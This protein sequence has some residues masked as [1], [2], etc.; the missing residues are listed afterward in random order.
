MP[1]LHEIHYCPFSTASLTPARRDSCVPGSAST[2]RWLRKLPYLSVHRTP[3]FETRALLGVHPA[4]CKLARLRT[5]PNAQE[6][7]CAT[8]L[9][10]LSLPPSTS[11]FTTLSLPLYPYS[12]LTS[13]FLLSFL[14][15]ILCGS[16]LLLL[17]FFFFLLSLLLL[18]SSLLTRLSFSLSLNLTRF[19][20]SFHPSSL[21]GT[22][23]VRLRRNCL[24]Q[25][26][27]PYEL[28]WSSSSRPNKSTLSPSSLFFVFRCYLAIVSF[29]LPP[30]LGTL[31]L[32][33]L[34]GGGPSSVLPRESSSPF[35]RYKPRVILSF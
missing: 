22:S 9:Y 16:S 15:P 18:L 21:R 23:I 19:S 35:E 12:T 3:L 33:R 28:L 24:L 25:L 5:K 31:K 30:S 17:L 29:S 13:H 8:S 6:R 20:A 27:L 11:F 32:V 1:L 4:G 7:T 14:L 26:L 34:R 2:S 10:V